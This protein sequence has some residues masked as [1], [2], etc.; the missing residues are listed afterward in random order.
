[1][2]LSVLRDKECTNYVRVRNVLIFVM[3][4]NT[5]NISP[6]NPLLSH[7]VAHN[8]DHATF[9]VDCFYDILHHLYISVCSLRIC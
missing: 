4:Y 3:I 1:M 6:F 5:E 2:F 8:C 7:N 9:N